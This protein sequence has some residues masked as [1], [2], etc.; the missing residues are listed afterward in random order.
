MEYQRAVLAALDQ[1]EGVVD[2]TVRAI[3]YE[4]AFRTAGFE[5]DTIP[6]PADLRAAERAAV[7]QWKTQ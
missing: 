5:A 4:R 7:R 2:A 1:T 6:A 3:A